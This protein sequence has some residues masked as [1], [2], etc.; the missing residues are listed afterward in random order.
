MKNVE[1]YCIKI[2]DVAKINENSWKRYHFEW[3][4]LQPK[5]SFKDTFN[6]L[7]S[8]LLLILLKRRH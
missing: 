3:Y 6:S 5:S 2:D 8:K 1:I 4:R 7:Q